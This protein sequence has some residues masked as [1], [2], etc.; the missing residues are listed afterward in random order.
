MRPNGLAQF[1]LGYETPGVLYEIPQNLVGFRP[2]VDPATV[3]TQAPA[4]Q[5]ELKTIEP[6]NPM[7]DMAHSALPRGV[8]IGL[9]AEFRPKIGILSP[10]YQDLRLVLP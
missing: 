5:I 10:V 8:I 9:S 2:H 4:R 7:I 1:L 6:Q 3:D